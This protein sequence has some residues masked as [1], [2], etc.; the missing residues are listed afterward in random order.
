M[1]LS[2]YHQWHAYLDD[3]IANL[4]PVSLILLDINMP[5]R[6]KLETLRDLRVLA[7]YKETPVVGFSTT[8]NKDVIDAY[9]YTIRRQ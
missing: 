7:T 2:F 8:H 4:P 6:N 3:T 1:T 5:V 9:I